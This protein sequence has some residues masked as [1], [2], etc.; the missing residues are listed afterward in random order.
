MLKGR[1]KNNR[2][3]KNRRRKS[4]DAGVFSLVSLN[5]MSA[6]FVKAVPVLVMGLA[7]VYGVL[8]IKD[9]DIPTVLPLEHIEVAGE[10][11]FLDKDEITAQVKNSIIGGYFSADLHAVRKVL[12]QNPW[13]KD[14]SLRRQWPESITVTIE[15]QAPVAYWNE[16]SYINVSGEVFTPP[17]IDR[18]LN[19]P[20]LNGPEGHHDNVWKFMNVLYQEMALLDVEVVRLDLDDRRAWQLVISTNI[21]DAYEDDASKDAV[22]TNNNI[23]VKLGRFDTEKRLKRFI[24]ILPALA[25]THHAAGD[26][27]KTIDMRYPNG[28]AV[29]MSSSIPDTVA[30][31]MTGNDTD[32]QRSINNLSKA[33]NSKRRGLN[34]NDKKV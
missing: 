22:Q 28:F 26:I 15:E 3:S 30:G 32:G 33:D 13:V 8:F 31:N 23:D 20:V 19:L 7:V 5:A 34:N 6:K 12:L 18:E 17:V 27:I 16:N 1:S 29:K 9:L 25:V 11:D 24:R 2:R 4:K 14:V 10:L 21:D